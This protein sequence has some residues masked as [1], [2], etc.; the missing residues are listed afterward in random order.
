MSIIHHKYVLQNQQRYF[1]NSKKQSSFLPLKTY[2]TIGNI[3]IFKR[4]LLLKV[5]VEAI[6]LSLYQRF[7]FILNAKHQSY[8]KIFCFFFVF[9]QFLRFLL[10][11][12]RKRLLNCFYKSFNQIDRS[13]RLKRSSNAFLPLKNLSQFYWSVNYHKFTGILV[14][15]NC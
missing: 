7:F 13:S 8:K 3:T 15:K 4:F 14:H 2:L 12:A 10:Q 1:D 9:Q 6:V 5:G 11:S